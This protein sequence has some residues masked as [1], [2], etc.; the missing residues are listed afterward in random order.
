M[1][2]AQSANRRLDDVGRRV[3]VRLANLEMD[4][5]TP[6]RFKGPR[7]REPLKRRL[8]P[9][10]IEARGKHPSRFPPP[11][12]SVKPVQ[13]GYAAA[14]ETPSTKRKA[15]RTQWKTIGIAPPNQRW[16]GR[17]VIRSV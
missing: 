17:R 7:A 5:A 12:A 8:S 16:S 2:V 10:A 4:D 6:L 13:P 11:Q 14:W 3:E 9:E 15:A 1:S